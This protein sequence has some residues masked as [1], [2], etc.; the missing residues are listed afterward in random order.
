VEIP[1][2]GN[3]TADPRLKYDLEANAFVIYRGEK[4][5]A[6]FEDEAVP[7]QLL[8]HSDVRVLSDDE[9][10]RFEET[11][12]APMGPPERRPRR[13]GLGDLISWLTIRV[14]IRECAGCGRRRKR[15]NKIAVWGWWAG[16]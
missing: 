9:G 10:R 13:T 3:T 1:T 6:T 12:P 5:F 2:L 14:G 8:H 15:L 7:E 16:E 11:L 4:A